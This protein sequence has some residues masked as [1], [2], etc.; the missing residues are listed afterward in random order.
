[1]RVSA[2]RNYNFKPRNQVS[3]GI[4]KDKKA[5]EIIEANSK[6]EC[7]LSI[8]SNS[9]L[10]IFS[11]EGQ[12]LKVELNEE[13]ANRRIGQPY[14]DLLKTDN[15]LNYKD[16][17]KTIEAFR[18]RAWHFLKYQNPNEP[19]HKEWVEARHAFVQAICEFAETPAGQRILADAEREKAQRRE[20]EIWDW[21]MNDLA[22]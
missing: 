3:F 17:A 7:T 2:V 5:Q 19:T 11:S 22:D 1:M 16:P 14:V 8:L 18:V 10:F 9:Q 13:F 20:R 15:A 6:N 4:I 21:V 12:K